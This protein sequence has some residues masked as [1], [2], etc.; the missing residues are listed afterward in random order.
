[1]RIAYVSDTYLPETN[2]IVTAIVRHAHGLVDRG[3]DVLVLCPRYRA[4]DPGSEPHIALDRHPAWSASSNPDTH[5]TLPFF[6]T[7]VAPLRRFRPDLVHVHT[8]LPLGVSGILAA[9][10]LGIPIVQTYH[11]W[12]PGI[13]QY[14]SLSRLLGLDRGPRH[15][16]D[17]A[18]ARF[19]TRRVYNRA[20][21]L[22]APS[23]AL[24][25]LLRELGLRPP[26]RCQTNGIDAAEFPPKTEWSLRRRVM[27]CGRLGFEKNAEVV[28]EAFARFAEDRPDW[29]LHL[30]G[31]GPAAPYLRLL[32]DRLGIAGRVR[33]EGF[34]SRERLADSYRE[35]DIYAT[36][37]TI[38]TQGL[39][40]LEAMASGTPV[41]GVDA[42]AVPEM[43]RHGRNAIIVE[44]YDRAAMASAFARI[45]D[46]DALRERMGRAG[47]EDVRVHDLD[48][49]IDR[50]ENTYEE[51]AASRRG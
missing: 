33:F 47:I 27:H 13:M 14:A 15:T 25:E 34:V 23:E 48:R 35:A 2:G 28:V 20:D 29:E 39:V 37:S 30:L 11:S 36:A 49:A 7:I 22:L 5:V 50:L 18:L 8:P 12:V 26:V 19:Y 9:R 41:V 46:D 42:L 10:G 38:E 21:L 40:V 16:H 3:H 43:A 17:T 44:P 24:C 51:L 4:D 32:I 31:E 45:A 1:M 6:P